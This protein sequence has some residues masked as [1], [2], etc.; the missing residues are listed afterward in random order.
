LTEHVVY[1]DYEG[2]LYDA[3]RD[4]S[5]PSYQWQFNNLMYAAQATIPIPRTALATYVG[6]AW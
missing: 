6:P 3:W 1:I 5:D 2:M 4:T